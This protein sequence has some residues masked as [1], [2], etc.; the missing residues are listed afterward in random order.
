MVTCL[1][2][3]PTNFSLPNYLYAKIADLKLQ[4]RLD[5]L[6]ELGHYL[7]AGGDEDLD[8]AV[9]Q[10]SIENQWFT[11]GNIRSALKAIA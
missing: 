10:S 4:E 11:E 6:A 3:Q 9:Q 1:R 7:R 5:L 2:L 8:A